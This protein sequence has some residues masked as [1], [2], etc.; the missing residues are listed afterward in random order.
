MINGRNKQTTDLSFIGGKKELCDV[1]EVINGRYRSFENNFFYT[2]TKTGTG[3]INLGCQKCQHNFVYSEECQECYSGI[4][5]YSTRFDLT[6]K[7]CKLYSIYLISY[8]YSRLRFNNRDK[9]RYN[10]ISLM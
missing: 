6:E 1:G 8:I 2:C 4:L 7:N 5:T 3:N 9:L 10:S